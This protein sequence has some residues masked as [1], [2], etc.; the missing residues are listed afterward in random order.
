MALL[1][2]DITAGE[3]SASATGA[4]G[5]GVSTTTM[6]STMG[7]VVVRVTGLGTGNTA[8]VAIEDTNN[9]SAFSDVA[10]VATFEFNGGSDHDGDTRSKAIYEL[11]DFRYGSTN[12]KVRANVTAISGG[13]AKV[14]AWIEQ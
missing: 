14:Y 13:T 12:T 1:K 2:Y 6:T 9:A 10:S 11:P 8:R 7:R 4:I 5:S 3:Q